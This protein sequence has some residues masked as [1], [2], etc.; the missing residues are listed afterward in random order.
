MRIIKNIEN[1]LQNE[2]EDFNININDK[3]GAVYIDNMFFGYDNLFEPFKQGM[4]KHTVD[5]EEAIYHVLRMTIQQAIDEYG[6]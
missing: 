1:K 5:T 6:W 3:E 2:F 4:A